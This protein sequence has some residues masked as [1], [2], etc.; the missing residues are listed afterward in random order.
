MASSPTPNR[1]K[2]PA[3]PTRH[4][5]DVLVLGGQVGGALAA[6]LL[7]RR[8]YKV[9]LV[10]HEP[11]GAG[12][13][14]EGWQLPYAPHVVP[15]LGALPALGPALDE[16]HLTAPAQRAVQPH[17]P[18]LQLVLPGVRLDLHAEPARRAAEL[19][20]ALHGGAEALRG[21]LAAA[22]EQ[23]APTDAFF[24]EPRALPP[25]GMMERWRLQREAAALPA[26]GAA[27]ALSDAEPADALL[28]GLLP[29]VSH[30]HRPAAPLAQTRPL[31]QVLRGPGR[32]VGGGG[33]G[34]RQVL[35]ARLVELGGEV[36]GPQSGEA[37]VVEH[38]AFSGGRVEGVKLLRSDTVY[39]ADAVV[40]AVDAEGLRRLVPDRKKQRALVDQ[41]DAS[42]PRD[43]LFAVNWVVPER[44]L[45]RGLGEL[46]LVATGDAELGALLLQVL[47]AR[48]A[49]EE[50]A[51]TR[52]VCAGAFVPASARE[53]GE[54]HLAAL[55]ARV[56][57][58]LDTLMPFT[59]GHRLHRSV[60]A[61]DAGSV[62]AGRL[63]PHPL[64]ALEGDAALGVGGLKQRT[65]LKNLLLAGREV[66]P[67]LGLEGE[68]LAGVRA[69]G[70]VQELLQKKD[71]LKG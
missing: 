35:L 28:R 60:V 39:R 21:R 27:P 61:L 53:L 4:V 69:A 36:L 26:L 7:A 15:P 37:H 63:L 2:A 65:P 64:F 56:E 51:S 14:S 52:V 6:A 58:Q 70:L 45:P 16:L 11:A 48:R 66:L 17:R 19:Q 62:R 59:A 32:F 41:L 67:G 40:A 47:P 44:A 9:L 38:L 68:V 23:G 8:G 12:Y 55:A 5:Y 25:E 22:A 43:F 13:E 20:R 30:L 54:E 34:L 71:P 42:T 18:E 50:V 33:A 29:F 3:G 46:A 10:E 1:P 24:R 49:G 31:S 57:A